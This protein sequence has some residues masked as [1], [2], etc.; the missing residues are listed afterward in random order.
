MVKITTETQKLHKIAAKVM[1][2]ISGKDAVLDAVGYEVRRRNVLQ[3]KFAA[4]GKTFCY[5][6]YNDRGRLGCMYLL[7]DDPKAFF[8]HAAN[9]AGPPTVCDIQ[10]LHD[11]ESKRLRVVASLSR[12]DAVKYLIS[13]ESLT[14][15]EKAFALQSWELI[16]TVA[17]HK[18]CGFY[19]AL[20]YS[21]K[22][23][24]P[25]KVQTVE[26]Q[27]KGILAVQNRLREM[28]NNVQR[29]EAA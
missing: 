17:R 27:M 9:I 13:E 7:T 26:D 20:R 2:W 12:L 19:E 18:D 5:C 10:A 6:F 23:S 16:K 14:A 29:S 11:A 8:D 3:G 4:K 15:N 1:P 28:S 22:F 21:L 25:V 24:E